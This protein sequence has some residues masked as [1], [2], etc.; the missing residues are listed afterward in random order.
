VHSHVPNKKYK[1]SSLLVAQIARPPYCRSRYH[2]GSDQEEHRCALKCT[3]CITIPGFWHH[4]RKLTI[5]LVLLPAV[6]VFSHFDSIAL[7]E[8]LTESQNESQ[9]IQYN[10]CPV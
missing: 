4:L 5:P 6:L 1:N 2:F 9:P 7:F 8:S 3:K 10:A